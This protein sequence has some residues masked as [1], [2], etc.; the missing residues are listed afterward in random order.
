[1]FYFIPCDKSH[2]HRTLKPYYV[3]ERSQWVYKISCECR[4]F[5]IDETDRPLSIRLK[6]HTGNLRQVHLETS[7]LA[8]HG[9]EEGHKIS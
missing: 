8:H 6:K 9:L 4:T 3:Q 5:H 1:V 7:K 2:G